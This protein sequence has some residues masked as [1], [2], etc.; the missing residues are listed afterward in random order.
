MVTLLFVLQAVAFYTLIE[1]HILGITQNR[2]GPK[3]VS[4][5]GIIQPLIDG[6]KLI[7]KEQL[8]IFNVTPRVFLGV[9]LISFI[10][11]FGE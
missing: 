10:L 7:S 11:L 5:Y 4:F 8:V 1:R 3:K 6:V 9:T 2:Y